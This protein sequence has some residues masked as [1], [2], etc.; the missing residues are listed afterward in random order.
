VELE[1][2]WESKRVGEAVQKVVLDRD[3]D[4]GSRAL[5]TSCHHYYVMDDQTARTRAC[6]VDQETALH[7]FKFLP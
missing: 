5:L 2:V 3:V 6:I 4:P 7:T 1:Q